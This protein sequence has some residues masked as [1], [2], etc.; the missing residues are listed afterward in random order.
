M[1]G[2]FEYRFPAIKGIQ[3]HR[4]YYVS[5]CPLKLIPKL[6]IFDEEELVPELKWLEND[7]N[8]TLVRKDCINGFVGAFEADG[9]N[10]FVEWVKK[11]GITDLLVVGI[12]TDICVMDFV[13]PIQTQTL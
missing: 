10:H 7:R 2:T 4:E 13:L 5:M 6:F 3:A 12:C 8:T 1:S 11:N 9:T